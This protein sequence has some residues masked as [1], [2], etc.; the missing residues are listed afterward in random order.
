MLRHAIPDYR[1]PRDVL[2]AEI[3]RILELGID[4]VSNSAVGE[5]VD[6][7][8]LNLM[9]SLVCLDGRLQSPSA[10]RLRL[11]QGMRGPVYQKFNL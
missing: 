6:L 7:G 8:K 9:P 2:D 1:L 11:Q 3:A 5:T 10:F 4:F